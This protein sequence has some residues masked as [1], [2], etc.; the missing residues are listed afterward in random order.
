MK[1]RY[2]L[3]KY[4]VV[5]GTKTDAYNLDGTR[6]IVITDAIRTDFPLRTVGNVLDAAMKPE[7]VVILTLLLETYEPTDVY[8]KGVD[9]HSER[10]KDVIARGILKDK[11]KRQSKAH[12]TK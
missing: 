7:D 10:A 9:I 2:R 5:V 11:E 1:T 4:L 3:K 6:K 8:T 12:R